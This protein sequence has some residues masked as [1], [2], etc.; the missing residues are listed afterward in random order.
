M[1][2]IILNNK[3]FKKK[4]RRKGTSL[5]LRNTLN[6]YIFPQIQLLKDN[7]YVYNCNF[8]FGLQFLVKFLTKL[9]LYKKF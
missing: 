8:S 7:N 4:K 3:R 9:V 1:K 5:A 2:Y 6:H